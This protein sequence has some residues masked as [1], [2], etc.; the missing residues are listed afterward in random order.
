[1]VA[2]Q[3][4]GP[5]DTCVTKRLNGEQKGFAERIDSVVAPRFV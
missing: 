4:L 3:L 1:M 2:F 5:H